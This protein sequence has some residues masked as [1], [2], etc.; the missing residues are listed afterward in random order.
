MCWKAQPFVYFLYQSSVEIYLFQSNEPNLK[1]KCLLIPKSWEGRK[2]KRTG[3]NEKDTREGLCKS[4]VHEINY[5][6]YFSFTFLRSVTFFV[7]VISVGKH[8]QDKNLHG[9]SPALQ[10]QAVI[11]IPWWSERGIRRRRGKKVSMKAKP[12]TS[13]STGRS[14]V[15]EGHRGTRKKTR[16]KKRGQHRAHAGLHWNFSWKKKTHSLQ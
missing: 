10:A 15:V 2:T 3:E 4:A 11:L 14:F 5:F 8:F 9:H 7:S 1:R 13:S 6:V 12:L 16:T